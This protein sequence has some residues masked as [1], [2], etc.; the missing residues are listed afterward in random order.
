M[1]GLHPKGE[2]G[3]VANAK[4]EIGGDAKAVVVFCLI[5]K[6]ARV[7]VIPVEGIV[8]LDM[9]STEDIGACGGGEGMEGVLGMEGESPEEGQDAK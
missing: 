3:S 1:K 5:V 9:A 4:T 7:T 6:G 2:F 8:P